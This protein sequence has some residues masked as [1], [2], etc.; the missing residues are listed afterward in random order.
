MKI[1]KQTLRSWLSNDPFSQS[2]AVAYYA[3]FSLPGLLI[4]IMGIAA[5]F[6]DQKS[7]EREVLGHIQNMLGVDAAR[8]VGKI[9]DETQ[10]NDRD[11]WAM[12]IGG[13]TLLFGATGLFAQL[14]KSLNFIWKVEVRK[15]VGF[16]KFIKHRATAF[17]IVVA[18]GFLLMVSLSVNAALSAL[19]DWL[20]TQ[21]PAYWLFGLYALNMAVSYFIISFLFALIFKVLPD[22]RVKWKF[23]LVGGVFS[24]TLFSIGEYGLNLYFKL[25]EPQSAFGAAGSV[26]LLMLWVSYSCLILLLGA[27][28]TKACSL[29]YDSKVKP[30]EI[31]KKTEG[32]S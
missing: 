2:A 4:I 30:S 1:I 25:A 6:F 29:E 8:S 26:V 3:T 28:F 27:E 21:I 23:S 18:I 16:L 17:G 10:R 11:V 31:A 22:V 9:V 19:G 5:I 13:F 12:V 24:A 20:E 32:K 14:Q 15:N 7:V